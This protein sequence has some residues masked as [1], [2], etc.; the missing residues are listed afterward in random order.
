MW[1][2]DKYNKI[3]M[4]KNVKVYVAG[5]LCATVISTTCYFVKSHD[6]ISSSGETRKE[7]SE[8]GS[9]ATTTDNSIIDYIKQNET[10][11]MS[12]KDEFKESI[13][14]II[15]DDVYWSREV[16]RLIPKG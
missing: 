14:H 16:E 1:I 15:E 3:T 12:A 2:N 5:F 4:F 13:E 10:Q 9:Q 8:T 7:L 11:T 6:G